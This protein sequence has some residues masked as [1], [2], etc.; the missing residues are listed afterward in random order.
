MLNIFAAVNWAKW[1]LKIDRLSIF[2]KMHRSPR[3]L[4]AQENLEVLACYV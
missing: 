3:A 2:H 1:A 4:Q